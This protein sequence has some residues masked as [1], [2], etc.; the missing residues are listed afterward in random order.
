[1]HHNKSN[2][3][4]TGAGIT[5]PRKRSM[6]AIAA[7]VAMASVLTAGQ[8]WALALGRVTVQSQ[9]GEPLR[10]EIDVP[11]ITSEEASSLQIGIAPPD[12]FRAASM[13]FNPLLNDVRFELVQ[14]PNGQFVIRLSSDRVVSEPFLDVVLQASWS[15]GQ[16]LRGY[17]ML[18]DPPN[19]RPAP[20]PLLPAAPP[21]P[22]VSDVRPAMPVPP[23]TTA[24]T[25][26]VPQRATPAPMPAAV[27][28]PAETV[29]RVEVRRGDTASGIVIS[30]LPPGV[31]LDQML[32]ALLRANPGA[33]INNNVNRLK[34]GAVLEIPDA[35][36]ASAIPVSEARQLIQA[37]S[38]DFNEFRR[39]LATMA[40]AQ[41]TA[42]ASRQAAGTVQTEVA[43]QQP[44]ATAQ[45]RL[46]LAQ[47]STAT[48]ETEQIAQTRQQ[49]AAQQRAD[50]L[51][52]NLQELEQL[53]Q[54]IAT[55]PATEAEPATTA[56][57][58]AE[59]PVAGV[60]VEAAAPVVP[61]P[62]APPAPEAPPAPAPAPAATAGSFIQSVTEHPYALPAGGVLA[63]LLGLLA[64]M[65]LRKRR[66][67]ED[68]E[69][70]PADADNQELAEGQ[71][72]DTNED[73][74]VSSMMY[75]P[76]QLDAG[77]DVDPVA[78]ADVYLAYGRE[79][80]AEEIL[81]EAIRL[82]PE[83]LPARLKLLEIY[84]G[85]QD[86]GAFDASARDLHALTGGQGEE[87]QQAR[88]LGQQLDPDNP[89]YLNLAS[90]AR[91]DEEGPLSA[92]PDIDLSFDNEPPAN[93]AA[94]D[95][96]QLLSAEYAEPE[97]QPT[98]EPEP[99]KAP[100]TFEFDLDTDTTAEAPPAQNRETT[101]EATA[102]S[103][104]FDLDLTALEPEA[105]A[106]SPAPAA[107]AL[108][109]E[110][111]DLSLDLDFDFDT[112]SPGDTSADIGA[113]TPSANMD[114]LEGLDLD[115]SLGGNDPLQTK[116]SLA[117]EF[118]AIGDTDGARS[119]A[120]EVEAEAT[121]ELKE[122]ARAFLARLS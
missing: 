2:G 33:F 102:S 66:T 112:A 61:E 43:D 115:E 47:G 24:V 51:N 59:P 114:A 97:A 30:Q 55:Q 37:Q 8:T 81:V 63:A 58:P 83:K 25:P 44:A 68:A 41:D 45:D 18:F 76:S 93:P 75:S 36:Q 9:L 113:S 78:E 13:E 20:A 5:S 60:T 120:E 84:A 109:D 87:W 57:A 92:P 79:K 35:A 4:G 46:T 108:P 119:L 17:T 39:R 94:D 111:K 121:G 74:P 40:P 101:P 49:E 73:P 27:T 107:A 6:N 53:R 11:S 85:R 106:P 86:V 23:P 32:I 28:A 95:L 34:A 12:R 70:D 82:H 88:A 122:R 71:T 16:L 98:Q 22:V 64:L 90:A 38:R 67:A 80:Q 19:L 104:D 26:S 77:G 1:M 116:L 54:A 91:T 14:R 62:V 7:A 31:S 50:E 110:I 29:R 117:E 99:S 96:E 89:L 65:R 15:N 21:P 105:P 100:D 56:D 52:R 10:A 69:E 42:P 118:D 103:L 3:P 72:V 48:A